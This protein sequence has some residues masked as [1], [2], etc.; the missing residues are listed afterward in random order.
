MAKW[1][2][3]PPGI[4]GP[5][6]LRRW[7]APRKVVLRTDVPVCTGVSGLISGPCGLCSSCGLLEF[8]PSGSSTV[9]FINASSVAAAL[10]DESPAKERPHTCPA[11]GSPALVLFVTAECSNQKCGSY[12]P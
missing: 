10:L 5:E 12:V 8:I 1:E 3:P 9:K 11:C 4:S 7:P 2:F 6:F